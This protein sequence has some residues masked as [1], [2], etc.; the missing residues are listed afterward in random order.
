M[1]PGKNVE[2]LFADALAEYE[3]GRFDRAWAILQEVLA[4]QPRHVPALILLGIIA[5]QWCKL[6]TALQAF[7]RALEIHPDN[8]RAHFNK[9]NI[10]LLRGEWE[11]GWP[12]Y[13]Y[14]RQLA[15]LAMTWPDAPAP[16]L[17]LGAE[18]LSGKRILLRCEQGLGDTLQFCRYVTAI[19]AKGAHVIL[20]A[21]RPLVSLLADLEG[22]GQIVTQGSRLP[23]CDYYCP[24]LSLPFACKTTP[25]SIPQP[26]P[27]LAAD[28]AKI[29]EWRRQLGTNSK[30][31]VGLVWRGTAARAN[32]DLRSMP[33]ESL[34]LHLP[35]E[36]QYVS[37]QKQLDSKE[38]EIL[39]RNPR[40][41]NYADQLHDFSDTAALCACMDLVVSIDTS[42]AHLSA[43]LGKPT[44]IL[45]PFSP[46]WRWLLD[47]DDSPWYRSARLL[48][49]VAPQEW[50]GVLERL[51]AQLQVS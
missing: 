24:L 27:Y 43:A 28:Q 50:S 19:A 11:R 12:H 23:A 31:R 20:E 38:L 48:R 40:I 51:A 14:R 49:Q 5:G 39:A 8:P 36:N 9:A 18:P 15:D 22:L 2:L 4:T 7:D 45:L 35:E 29:A 16:P 25:A 13:E 44:W 33:L 42:V 41:A 46:A 26:Q 32:D 17:W 34:L 37:L 6:D 10:L 21:Q 47:R 1:R 3:S 30:P